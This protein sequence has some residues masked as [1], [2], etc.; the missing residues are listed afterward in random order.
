[1]TRF[2][3]IIRVR[4]SPHNAVYLEILVTFLD[5][6]ERDFYYSKAKIFAAYRDE[7]GKPTA[8]I[9]MDVAPFLLATFK[10]LNNHGFEIRKAHGPETRRYV[11]YDDKNMSFIL[12]VK[13]PRSTKWT[14]IRPEQAKSY[15]EEK[16]RLEYNTIRRGMLSSATGSNPNMIPLGLRQTTSGGRDGA[17]ADVPDIQKPPATG[18]RWQPP[19]RDTPVGGARQ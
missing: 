4:S 3:S 17:R 1:M 5:Q 14:R 7:D 15:G 12:E 2:E 18:Q 6:E 11:K 13:L 19:V 9:R 8:G 10:L 16:D